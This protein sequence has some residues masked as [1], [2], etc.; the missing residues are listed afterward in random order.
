[1]TILI[2]GLILFIGAHSI[3]IISFSLRNRLEDQLGTAAWK[4][5]YSIVALVGFVLLVWGY[6]MARQ[7]PELI[8]PIY[9]LPA[10]THHLSNLLMLFVFPLFFAAYLPGRIQSLTKHPMLL[11]TTLWAIAHLLVNGGLADIVLFGTFLVWSIAD[12]V[13]LSMRPSLPVHGAP[14]SKFNDVIAIVAGIVVY[15]AFVF[16]LHGLLIGVPL[17]SAG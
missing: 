9:T 12:R 2:I 11:A 8:A 7:Q 17:H 4:G 14:P 10:W 6:G 1:M 15:G 5:I 3:S 16:Y 13:S